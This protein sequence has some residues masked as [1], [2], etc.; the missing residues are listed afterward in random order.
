MCN[1]FNIKFLPSRTTFLPLNLNQ[2]SYYFPLQI[3]MNVPL[4]LITVMIPMEYVQ[5]QM[6]SFTCACNAGFN[7]DGVTCSGNQVTNKLFHFSTTHSIGFLFIIIWL[8]FK[9]NFHS[10]M[11][12]TWSIMS[13]SK[14]FLPWRSTFIWLNLNNLAIIWFYRY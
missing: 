4:M 5:I 7:G 1:D 12:Q 6:G 8:F 11:G 14:S 9:Y 3:L 13:S 2:C 10:S